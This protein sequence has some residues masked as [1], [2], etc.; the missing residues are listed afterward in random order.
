M[1]KQNTKTEAKTTTRN[2]TLKKW[3]L[4]T[5]CNIAILVASHP[6]IEDNMLDTLCEALETEEMALHA[7]LKSLYPE[8]EAFLYK[9][10]VIDINTSDVVGPS[11]PTYFTHKDSAYKYLKEREEELNSKGCIGIVRPISKDDLNDITNY[12]DF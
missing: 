1:N 12:G 11:I 9:V 3:T 10:E 2:E 4:E 7:Y 6:E 8:P 5:L